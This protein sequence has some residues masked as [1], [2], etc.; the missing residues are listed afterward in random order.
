M[1]KKILL[2]GASGFVG[3]NFLELY[4]KD[5]EIVPVS[6]RNKK[7]EDIDFKGFDCVVHCAALVHQ[8]KGAPD[9][10]Y[11]KINFELT[12]TLAEAAK[13]AGVPQ[14]IFLSTAHVFGDSGS[15]KSHEIK[16]NET[17]VCTPKDAYGKSKLAAENYLFSIADSHFTVSVIRPP[18]VYGK[19]AKGNIITLGKLIK[20]CP[21]LPFKWDFNKRSIVF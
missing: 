12:K 3:G 9:S 4:N 18:M 7:I 19:G 17:T 11:F 21:V 5:F 8:M 6:L 15:L 10:E 14:F 20:L 16:L 2:T 13:A 1:R